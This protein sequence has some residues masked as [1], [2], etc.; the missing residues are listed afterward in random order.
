MFE[1]PICEISVDLPPWLVSLPQ[2]HWLRA[3]VYTAVNTAAGQMSL[4]RDVSLLTEELGQCEYITG[5]MVSSMRLGEGSA[6]ISVTVHNDLFY[7]ILAEKTGLQIEGEQDLMRCMA[8]L[9]KIKG[10]YERLQNA[11]DEVEATGYG[12]VMPGINELTLEEPE[13]VRRVA[14]DTACG[15]VPPHRPFICSRRIFARRSRLLSAVKA[16]PRSS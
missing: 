5:A 10:E 4:V 1:F 16:S 2:E 13:I 8:E 9:A 3:A 14:A 6:W 15:F 7:K 11:L 12:I